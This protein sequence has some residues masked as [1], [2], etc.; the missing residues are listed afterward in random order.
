MVYRY[1]VPGNANRYH[2]RD[3]SPRGDLGHAGIDGFSRFEQQNLRNQTI[4]SGSVVELFYPHRPIGKNVVRVC[5]VSSKGESYTGYLE[6]LQTTELFRV[7]RGCSAGDQE[8]Q[9]S[10]DI[11]V[12]R[13]VDN[14]HLGASDSE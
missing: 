9:L 10:R 13:S 8:Y 2:M 4:R 1:E 6:V 11:V 14:T 5:F 7:L 12:I 3:D